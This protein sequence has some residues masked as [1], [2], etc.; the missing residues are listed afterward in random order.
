M[1][2]FE[3]LTS[4]LSAAVFAKRKLLYCYIVTLLCLSYVNS[5]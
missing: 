5:F 1:L 4:S 2:Y 3:K